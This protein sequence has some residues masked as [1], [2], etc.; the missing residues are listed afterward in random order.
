MKNKILFVLPS[1]SVGGAE[2]QAIL[3]ARS[4]SARYEVTMLCFHLN[5][6]YVINNRIKDTDIELHII[7][8]HGLLGRGI[9]YFKFL[10]LF[11]YL[12]THRYSVIMP[13]LDEMNL[14]VGLIKCFLPYLT[15]VW[16]QRDAGLAKFSFK[17]AKRSVKKYNAFISN[18]K[19]GA[20]FLNY[21]F[22]VPN[23]KI[24]IIPNGVSVQIDKSRDDWRLQNGFCNTD[25]LVCM[26]AN[27]QDNKDHITLLKSWK[28]IEEKIENCKLLLVGYKG[29]TYSSIDQFIADNSLKKVIVYGKTNEPANLLNAMDVSILSSKS[30]GLS[31]TMLETLFL[32]VPFVGTRITGITQVLGEDYPFLFDFGDDEKLSDIVCDIYL[33]KTKALAVATSINKKVSNEY[34]VNSLFEKTLSFLKNKTN[35]V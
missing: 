9:R 6:D 18:S 30:E 20:A 12:V 32:G 26:L 4:L 33:D 28:V 13:Y 25:F 23:E 3:L 29:S 22:N 31:N 21:K 1:T 24:A 16:N 10:S 34:S 19:E 27:L 5:E 2:T 14:N 35:L 17:L 7:E 15:I 8:S 11:W